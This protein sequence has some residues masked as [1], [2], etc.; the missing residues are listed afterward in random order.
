MTVG[1]HSRSKKSK[2]VPTETI[3]ELSRKVGTAFQRP[4]GFPDKQGERR[5]EL[6]DRVW[7]IDLKLRA[8]HA[9]AGHPE[10]RYPKHAIP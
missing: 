1:G 8:S 9:E 4:A 3:Y 5:L 2:V 10:S 7:S 6:L